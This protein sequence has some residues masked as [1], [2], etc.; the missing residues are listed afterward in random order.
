[1]GQADKALIC[2]QKSA[3]LLEKAPSEHYVNQGFIRAW[4]GE[5]LLARKEVKLAYAFYR[6]AYLKWEQTAPLRAAQLG[7][8]IDQ[9]RK[10]LKT[11]GTLDDVLVRRICL[12]WI[13][14]KYVDTRP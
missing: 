14:G 7:L 12:D 10:T 1:M 3:L 11:S 6:A 4:I 5:L 8:T 9:L 13:L 2:Y